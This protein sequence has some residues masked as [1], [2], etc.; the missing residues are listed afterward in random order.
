VYIGFSE[1][2]R[3]YDEAILTSQWSLREKASWLCKSRCWTTGMA[4]RPNGSFLSSVVVWT[5]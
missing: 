3:G 4:K 2:K 1:V 5:S